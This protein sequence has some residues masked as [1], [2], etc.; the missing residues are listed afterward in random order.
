MGNLLNTCVF[1]IKLFFLFLFCCLNLCS[2]DVIVKKDGSTILSK[3]LEISPEFVKYKKWKNLQGPTY[4]I[5]IKDILSINY[6]NGEKEVFGNNEKQEELVDVI[7]RE[8][9]NVKNSERNQ[10]LLDLYNRNY[11]PTVAIERKKA[12]EARQCISIYGIKENSL[13]SNDEIEMRIERGKDKDPNGGESICFFIILENKTD[14]NIYIDLGNSFRINEDGT[15][16]CYY[17]T[18]Q[19]SATLGGNSGGG[20]G[21]GS[22]AGVLGVDGKIG[23]LANGVTLGGMTNSAVTKTYSMD[24]IIIIPPYAKKKLTDNKYLKVKKERFLSDADF[25]KVEQ[26]ENFRDIISLKI[27]KG[28]VDIGKSAFFTEDQ[29]PYQRKYIIT[30]SANK[31]F[32]SYSTLNATVYL[33]QVIGVPSWNVN[34]DN[35]DKCIE[36]YNKYTLVSLDDLYLTKDQVEMVNLQLKLGTEK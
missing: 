16:Q 33:R 6:E 31:S 30:Y 15:F 1:K 9:V 7:Q 5:Y 4:S 3:I 12:K 2:Q 25:E 35:I 22:V 13:I 19:I 10:T 14:R 34:I 26:A 32:Q 18:E 17:N 36:D 24:R 21:L 27:P 23:Q 29:S 11:Q 28:I 20:I 8:V